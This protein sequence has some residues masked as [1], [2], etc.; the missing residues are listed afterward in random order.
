MV[1]TLDVGATL[2]E[3]ARGAVQVL[4]ADRAT[5]FL[6]SPGA[7]RVAAV[8]STEPDPLALGRLDARVGR[9]P[10][11]LPL[12]AKALAGEDG[13]VRIESA[14]G[15]ADLP[16]PARRALGEG[17]VLGVLL[18]D[19]A[20]TRGARPAMLGALM[21]GY[22]GPRRFTDGDV[23]RLR[24]LGNLATV[25]IA[26]ARLHADTEHALA[27]AQSVSEE[28]RSLHRVSRALA[29]STPPGEVLALAAREVAG[30]L[31]ADRGFVL[32]FE[33]SSAVVHGSWGEGASP[34]GSPFPLGGDGALAELLRTEGPVRVD[35]YA[36]RAVA[37]PDGPL[38]GCGPRSA[39]AAP[40]RIGDGLWGAVLAVSLTPSYFP[41]RALRRL[42]GFAELL[43]VGIAA[44]ESRRLLEAQALT[45][46]LTG[47]PNRRAFAERLAAEL[48]RARRHG[49]A[50]SLA[51]IDVDRFKRV[52]DGH[53]H[54]VGDD[55]L[56]EIARRLT[57]TARAGE[58]LAR[59]GGDEFSWILPGAG[60]DEALE[61][62][63]R[64]C[65]VVAAT[66]VPGVGPVTV[67]VGVATTRG[68]T[69]QD[70]LLSRA[71]EALYRAKSQG[72]GRAVAS[73][74]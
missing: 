5:C 26:N 21:C 13:L 56:A 71:D 39:V 14:A 49:H 35:D 11:S 33:G 9:D 36:G 55:A 12:I 41:A 3:I 19:R 43:E 32:A 46:P 54:R 18:E 64:A 74:S 63:V 66:P 6:F 52:N 25:A 67:S 60:S 53:G 17:A 48:R 70:L 30:L 34:P 50:V 57:A 42:D 69:A 47:L 45:D 27:H 23:T 51:M 38:A 37:G 73:A 61:A 62:A 16:E 29:A 4:S 72:R 65:R 8:F 31:R 58:L 44:A 68:E 22:A 40:L 28:L 20:V 1:R 10:E 59:T 15:D 2:R 24:A 7:D